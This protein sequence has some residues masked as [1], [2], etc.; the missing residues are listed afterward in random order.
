MCVEHILSPLENAKLKVSHIYTGPTTSKYYEDMVNC[1]QDGVLMVH[2]SKMYPT[3]ECTFFQVLAR[4]M[5]G[6]LHAGQDVRI[7]GENYT[8]QDEEDSR[9]LTVGRLWIYEAR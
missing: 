7:L 9:V 2:S 8:L 6:T 1:D 4:V 5:S 3:E